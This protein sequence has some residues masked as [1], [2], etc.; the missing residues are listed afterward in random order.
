MDAR[1]YLPTIVYA[2]SS[3]FSA[4]L[5]SWITQRQLAKIDHVIS[6]PPRPY[7][8]GKNLRD[9]PVT[10]RA[11][12]LGLSYTT[13]HSLKDK[14]RFKTIQA[15]SFDYLLVVAFG[16]I[17]PRWLLALPLNAPLNIHASLL[18]RWRGASPIQRALQYDDPFTGVC[19]ME[20]TEGLDEGPILLQ[21]RVQIEKTDSF[22]ILEGKILS[23]SQNLLESFLSCDVKP[24]AKKQ[25]GLPSYASKIVKAEGKLCAHDSPSSVI[26]RFRAFHQ[27]PGL[28]F[29]DKN[30]QQTIKILNI[31]FVIH[32]STGPAGTTQATQQGL[33]INFSDGAI[34]ATV[35]QFPGK[36]PLNVS[37]CFHNSGHVIHRLMLS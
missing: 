16:L 1:S 7:G 2:G 18:P 19:L 24:V 36:N 26:N 25:D 12:E 31:S 34:V 20:M 37:Q 21:K 3:Q 32:N 8:R 15:L 28:F 11:Q 30:S 33:M 10:Q 35:I 17:I 27:W 13:T 29:I 9:N 4:N 6:L 5:L 23:I 22:S 14:E